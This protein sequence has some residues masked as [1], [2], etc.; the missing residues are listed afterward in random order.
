MIRRKWNKASIFYYT[1]L[2]FYA[3][4]LA[5]LSAYMLESTPPYPKDEL[6]STIPCSDINF[7]KSR[8]EQFA[9][10]W[11]VVCCAFGK[12]AIIPL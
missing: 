5:L 3:V 12:C 4:F 2:V 10:V 9:T 8:Y 6:N 7:S 1:F 11:M